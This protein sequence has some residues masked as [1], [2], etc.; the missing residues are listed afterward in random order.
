MNPPKPTSV[1]SSSKNRC[2]PHGFS[3]RRRA[4]S[5][6]AGS[7]SG[8]PIQSVTTGMANRAL[9]TSSPSAKRL[10]PVEAGG[11]HLDHNGDVG[12]CGGSRPTRFPSCSSNA[13]RPPVASSPTRMRRRR[14]RWT[15]LHIVCRHSRTPLSSVTA[16]TLGGCGEVTS[17]VQPR[18]PRQQPEAPESR[19]LP[20]ASHACSRRGFT[21]GS[22]PAFQDAASWGARLSYSDFASERRRLLSRSVSCRS[23]SVVHSRRARVVVMPWWATMRPERAAGVEIVSSLSTTVSS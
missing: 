1:P 9:K 19:S 16:S 5:M 14:R 4:S 10:E 11:Q 20:D 8:K 17:R 7:A 18:P 15:P 21:R 6:A 23:A 22:V 13:A 3:G 12:H 2:V